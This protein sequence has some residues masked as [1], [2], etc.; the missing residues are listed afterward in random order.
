M[1]SHKNGITLAKLD[2]ADLELLKELKNESWFGTHRTSFVNTA[3][4]LKWFNSITNLSN[5][6]VALNSDGDRVGLYKMQNIDW[7][8]RRYD[9]AHDVFRAYRGRGY[10]KRVLAAGVDL[11]FE[12][13]NMNRIDTEVLSNNRASLK[14]ALAVGFVQEGEKSNCIYKCGSYLSNILLGIVRKDWTM[15]E[16]VQQYDGVCN[17]SYTPKDKE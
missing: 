12:V 9:S 8:S 15:L 1:Y 5:I 17:V 11:G 2:E 7:I 16:R 13:Y 14:S 6:F 3:D 4:Q 10:S